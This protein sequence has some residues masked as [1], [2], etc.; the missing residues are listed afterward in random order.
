M[1]S[2]KFIFERL[3]KC[4][5]LLLRVLFARMFFNQGFFF[6][7]RYKWKSRGTKTCVYSGWAVALTLM[8]I[9]STETT[10]V[11]GSADKL[12]ASLKN[13]IVED[14][15]IQVSQHILLQVDS[16]YE[17]SKQLLHR[18]S[19][20]NICGLRL[21]SLLCSCYYIFTARKMCVLEELCII[22]KQIIFIG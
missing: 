22:A 14:W 3:S 11:W 15:S 6:K 7:F 1:P 12:W 8:W 9:S 5:L 17:P 2:L 19:R 13:V 4:C 18:P 20:R 21:K 16:I 10:L